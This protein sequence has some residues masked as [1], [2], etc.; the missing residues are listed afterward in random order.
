[1]YIP[2][3]LTGNYQVKIYL[4]QTPLDTDSLGKPKQPIESI[5]HVVRV[6]CC[7]IHARGALL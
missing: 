3:W 1:M 7:S 5:M 2:L 6:S 4:L